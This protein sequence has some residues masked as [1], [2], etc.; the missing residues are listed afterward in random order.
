VELFKV[1][2]DAQ[3]IFLER[4]NRFLGRVD[5]T[6]PFEQKD[7]LI[8]VH[9][10]GR[11]PDLLIPGAQ[12]RIK[13]AVN[14]N[15]KTGWDLL[16]VKNKDHWVF[17]N[18]AYHRKIVEY[19]LARQEISPFE[20]V[21]AIQPEV[22]VG[23]SRLD[24]CLTLMDGQKVFIE[25][26]GCTLAIDEKA[27]F[28]DAPTSR[29]CRHVAELAELRQQGHRT[30]LITL[31]FREDASCFA[32]HFDIDPKFSKAFQEAFNKGVEHYSM[33]IGYKDSALV[34]HG[35]IPLCPEAFK[36]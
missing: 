9:D 35:T 10:P 13:K 18:S 31:V 28:P 17:V 29:G 36:L 25:T 16:A 22:R 4:P 34:Y 19:I 24:F 5:I 1:P 7:V 14:P 6:S 30:A 3:G 20:H 2:Y 15:R 32:P 12:V 27:L 11:L 8:H 21:T 23:K 26:K 33:V